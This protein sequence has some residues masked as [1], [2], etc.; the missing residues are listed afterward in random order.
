[1]KTCKKIHRVLV[2]KLG[3]MGD[4][5]QATGPFQAIR[6]HHSDAHIALLTTRA[7]K[8]FAD[9]GKWFDEV[10]IDKR[11]TWHEWRS[12][13]K[14]ILKIRQ[15][16]YNRIYDLQTSDRTAIIFHLLRLFYK[17]D[18]CGAA[19]GCSHYHD[20]PKRDLMH[21]LERQAE[22][23]S[24][25]SVTNVPPPN[26]NN[27]R[28]DGQKFNLPEPYVLIAPGGSSHRPEKRWPKKNYAK[29]AKRLFSKGITPVV[30]GGSAEKQIGSEITAYCPE[31]KDL[32]TKTSMIDIIGLSRRA[33]GS[34]G[35]D[36]GPMHIIGA[37][38]T[39]TLV[40]FSHSSDPAVCGQRGEDV[41]I[42]RFQSLEDLSVD[43]VEAN[44]RLR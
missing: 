42:L 14:L 34:V 11:P 35:N 25:A 39:P 36:T 43:E 38:G 26:L 8:E 6:D 17:V 1:M 33:S 30:I 28:S 44:M 23:L 22:Q 19:L 10:L 3:A 29:L 27:I 37:T 12:W 2:I 18:W 7:Y 16:K 40:L 20:N 41:K 13:T 5:V 9:S 4:M 15:K 21:T 31:A 32:T 24:L